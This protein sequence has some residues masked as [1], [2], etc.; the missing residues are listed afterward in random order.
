MKKP[1]LYIDFDHTLL[2]TEAFKHA[3]ARAVQPL[4]ISQKFFWKT[5]R[6]FRTNNIFSIPAFVRA[7]AA[8]RAIRHGATHALEQITQSGVRFLYP[9]ALPFLRLLKKKGVCCV[10]FT[11]GNP[12]FQRMKIASIPGHRALFDRVLVTTNRK[13]D[14]PVLRTHAPAYIIDN[15]PDV[16]LRAARHGMTPFVLLRGRLRIPRAYRAIAHRSLRT[17]AKH[18]V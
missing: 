9:D 10:V 13:K 3:L 2:D 1:T 6:A 12:R 11:Y 14:V 4:G 8:D 15:R 17:I 16:V 18:I 7:L 5:Y